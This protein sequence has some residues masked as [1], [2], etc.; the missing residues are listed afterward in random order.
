M[1]AKQTFG[2]VGHC[3][4]ND[5]DRIVDFIE[6]NLDGDIVMVRNSWGKIWIQEE[7]NER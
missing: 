1:P 2:I 6:N 3:N 4:P 7:K 5:L